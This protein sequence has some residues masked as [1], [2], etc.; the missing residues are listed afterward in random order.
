[1][2]CADSRHPC[3]VP[4]NSWKASFYCVPL[5]KM[6]VFEI[7]VFLYCKGSIHPSLMYTFISYIHFCFVVVIRDGY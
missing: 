7:Y 3:L 4:S 1:M 6:L 5:K 2:L